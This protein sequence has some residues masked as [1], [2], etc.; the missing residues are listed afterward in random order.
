M[1][2]RLP[3]A[4]RRQ[5]L[6]ETALAPV[7]RPRH[8]RRGAMDDIADAVGV[9]KP[10]LYQ[11]FR[12]RSGRSFTEPS[13]STTSAS[14]CCRDHQ[15][16]PQQAGTPRQ[17]VE[18]WS[19]RPT[20]SSSPTTTVVRAAVRRRVVRDE[21]FAAPVDARRVAIADFIAGRD[22]GRP[23][24]T[25]TGS[26]ARGTDRRASP[27]VRVVVGWRRAQTNRRRSRPSRGACRRPR[28]GRSARPSTGDAGTRPRVEPWNGEWPNDDRDANFK[29]DVVL[30]AHSDPLTHTRRLGNAIDI[31]SAG[32]VHYV[33]ARWASG[34]SAAPARDRPIDGDPHVGAGRDAPKPR[35]RRRVPRR[36]RRA[37][38]DAVVAATTATRR[39][40]SPSG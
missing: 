12:C 16:P 7:R 19:H 27:R 20:S 26:A 38:A 3:A 1:A 34:G 15:A 5:Q 14:T 9:T 36:V 32:L 37:D 35:H 25:T 29:S 23:R 24:P 10:V 6:I 21:E 31:P 40:L 18:A 2:V 13:C 30:Y 17:Q 39:H 8:A 22:R 11:H 4:E 28:V 33:L